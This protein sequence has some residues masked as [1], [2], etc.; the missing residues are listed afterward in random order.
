MTAPP[1]DG[2]ASR[3]RERRLALRL[4]QEELA[5]ADLS[6][7]YVSLL[8]AGKRTPTAEVLAYLAERLQ[9]SVIYLVEGVDPTERERARLTLEYADL[10]IR[11]GEAADALSEVTSLLSDEAGLDTELR[12]RAR[13]LHARA[14]E[15]VGRLEDCLAELEALRLEAATSSRPTDEL[16]LAVDLV[17][18]Y[19]E[20]GDTTL[21]VEL[22]QSTLKRLAS[23]NLAGT[24]E[25]A[26]LVSSLIGAYYERG[27]LRRAGMLAK[28]AIAA[29]D[30][31]GSRQAR[32]AIY[33]NA[34]LTTEAAGDTPGALVLAERAVA[35]LAELDEAR[36]MG[37]LRTAFGWLFLRLDPPDPERAFYELRTARQVLLDVGS[38]VDLAYCET[39]LGRCELL[40]GHPQKALDHTQ[41]AQEHLG[42]APRVELAHAGLVEGQALLAVGRSAE[43]LTAYEAAGQLLATLGVP[44]QGAAAWR[45]LGDVY[46]ELGMLKEATE[47][48]KRALSDVGIRAAPLF[49]PNRDEVT[50]T[51]AG[52][53]GRI[54]PE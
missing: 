54:Q 25:H 31:I 23:L 39:E 32:A 30:A 11:N 1:P 7:S 2:F 50:M 51:R 47:A 26:Q 53:L 3:L 9:C 44:R 16:Q 12:W 21:A 17:R 8:E 29:I 10:A 40:L 36:G 41:A 4:S 24:D 49:I 46:S 37:R 5:G 34:S 13:R 20:V 18:C 15:R 33:W 35:L 27:D 42:E 19:Q 52:A 6:A 43:A 14:L 28:A 22:G 48:Y 38:Q 45:E